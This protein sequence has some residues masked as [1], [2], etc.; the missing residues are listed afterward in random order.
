MEIVLGEHDRLQDGRNEQKFQQDIV[1]T[2][3]YYE[4]RSGRS[5]KND[6]ALIR[7]NDDIIFDENV[8]PICWDT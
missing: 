7:L 8:L 6:I 1:V 5:P 4:H 3:E 2:H